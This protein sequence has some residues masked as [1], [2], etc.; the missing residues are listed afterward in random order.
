MRVRHADVE[1]SDF[2]SPKGRFGCTFREYFTCE[3]TGSPFDLEHVTLKAGKRNF[4]FHSHGSLWELYYAVSGTATMRT[5]EE[6]VDLQVGDV[7]LCR[8]GL[9]HQI[10]NDSDE[11]FLYLVMSNDPPHDGCYYPDSGKMA[12]GAK[13]MWGAMPEDRRFWQPL[14]GVEYF[15]GEE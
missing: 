8:P 4:P 11:D 14:E 15:T 2:D 6:T 13:K 12:P 7:Y 10:I 5:D 3:D 1:T 9:A